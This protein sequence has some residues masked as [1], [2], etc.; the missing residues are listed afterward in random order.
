MTEIMTLLGGLVAVALLIVYLSFAWGYVT[1]LF[2]NW[3]VLTTFPDLPNIT[4]IQFIG[5]SFF[6]NALIRHGSVHIKD[7]YKDKKMEY[8]STFVSPW[9][10]LFFGWLIKLLL[11]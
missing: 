11:F 10:I 3:F 6:I 8:T 5:L 1:Y 4:V 9:I 7:E 2:Y